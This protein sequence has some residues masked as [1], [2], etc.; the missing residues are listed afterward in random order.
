[1]TRDN[2]EFD[3]VLN[4][5]CFEEIGTLVQKLLTFFRLAVS[6]RNTVHW[7]K[8]TPVVQSTKLNMG[9]KTEKIQ[10]H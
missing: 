3:A 2:V 10:R 9:R 4:Q 8:S 1:M 7:L 6:N 5:A